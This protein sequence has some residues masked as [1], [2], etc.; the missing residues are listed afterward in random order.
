MH[1]ARQCLSDQIGT[2]PT[3]IGSF[4]AKPANVECRD[5]WVRQIGRALC[6]LAENQQVAC[7][8]GMDVV[9]DLFPGVQIAVVEPHGYGL[10]RV[11]SHRVQGITAR[12][13]NS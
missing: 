13:G 3:G 5:A 8:R 9:Y 2:R 7:S 11:E 1:H 12:G 4:A 10:I 6:G